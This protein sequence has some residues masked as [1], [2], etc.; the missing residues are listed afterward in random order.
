METE[1]KPKQKRR[2]S[3]KQLRA[4]QGI[5]T[6][7]AKTNVYSSQAGMTCFGAVR[8]VSDIRADNS[9]PE[10]Q[11]ELTMTAKTNIYASQKG[12]TCFGA[13]R[14]GSDIRADNAS[15]EG[16]STSSL[17]TGTNQ[18]ASQKGMRGFGAVRH[19]SDIKVK[20]LYEEWPDDEYPTDEDEPMQFKP[21]KLREEIHD[22][23]E[24]AQ[25]NNEVNELNRE[26]KH[27]P[28]VERAYTQEITTTD[29]ADDEKVQA[30]INNDV[31]EQTPEDYYTND[32][33]NGGNVDTLGDENNENDN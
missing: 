12:M 30:E 15:L 19:G 28:T 10:G 16:F 21:R 1:E 13:V 9:C 5:L 27:E 17:Q 31:T 32:E 18:F 4:S 29:A 22:V 7:Q 20:E 26:V 11:G 6:M 33:H 23:N 25:S 3:R 2:F 8:H 24:N 14:H